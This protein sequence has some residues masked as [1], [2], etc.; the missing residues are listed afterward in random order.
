[1]KSMPSPFRSNLQIYKFFQDVSKKKKKKERKEKYIYPIF[2][3][4]NY[5]SY[6]NKNMLTV[7]NKR[8]QNE[9]TG[10]LF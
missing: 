1:M 7:N 2:I 8:H 10:Y 4:K 5:R 3:D 6:A 9:S